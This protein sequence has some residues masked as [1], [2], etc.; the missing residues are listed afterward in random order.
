MGLLFYTALRNVW[1]RKFRSMATASSVAAGCWCALLAIGYSDWITGYLMGTASRLGPGHMTISHSHFLEPILSIKSISSSGLDHL[2]TP[3]VTFAPRIQGESYINTAS[4]NTGAGYQ[5]IDPKKEHESFNVFISSI[6]QGRN[7]SSNKN[8]V[9]IGQVMATKLDMQLGDEIIFT[10]T[11]KQGSTHAIAQKIVGIFETGD[12]R[13]DAFGLVMSI[14]DARRELNF[15]PAEA[16]YIAVFINDFNKIEETFTYF[17][18][19][20]KPPHTLYHWNQ[21][22]PELTNFLLGDRIRIFIMVSF[23]VLLSS[24]GIYTCMVMNI[25]ERRRELGTMIAVGA[26]PRNLVMMVTTEAALLGGLGIVMGL[27]FTAP[28]YYIASTEG[29]D[30]T[31][32]TGNDFSMSL[33][34]VVTKGAMIK[35]DLSLQSFLMILAGIFAVSIIAAIPTSYKAAHTVPAD[36]IRD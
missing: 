9:L 3:G 23:I 6:K 18:S 31:F 26:L 21:T 22:M 32:L 14:E 8:E 35:T 25:T 34:G 5:A 7:I 2:R 15:G 24:S 16:S 33:G 36:T 10:T 4:R 19:R 30:F 13:A 17:T 11:N 28:I 12:K 20:I 1:R 29:I 27:V